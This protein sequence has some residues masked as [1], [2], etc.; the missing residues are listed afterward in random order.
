MFRELTLT[1]Y[2]VEAFSADFLFRA[3]FKPRGAFLIYMNDRTRSFVPFDD[4]ELLPV[5]PDRQ[6]KGIKQSLMVV[7]KTNLQMMSVINPEQAQ[8]VQLLQSKR[9]AVFYTSHL[10]IQGQLHV[11]SDSRDDDLLDDT[12]D[13]FALT[14]ATVYPLRTIALAPLRQVPL[15]LINRLH[16]QSYH[17]HTAEPPK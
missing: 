17:A 4:V 15:L 9:P 14:D 1:A 2:Q 8:S 3:S 7:N 12:R 5:A 10:A 11:N 6:V 16:I 13:F